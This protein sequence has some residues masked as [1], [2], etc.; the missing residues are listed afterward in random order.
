MSSLGPAAS[1]H[2][3]AEWARSRRQPELEEMLGEYRGLTAVTKVRSQVFKSIEGSRHWKDVHEDM[4]KIESHLESTL[5]NCMYN[6][7]P[8]SLF[9]LH[10][11]SV[12]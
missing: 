3:H 1:A 9:F 5:P 6:T 10:A 12:A 7:I 8:F 11:S 4:P 2:T